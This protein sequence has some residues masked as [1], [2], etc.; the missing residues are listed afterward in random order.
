MLLG[1]SLVKPY[2]S[3]FENELTAAR[4]GVARIHRQVHHD[5]IELAGVGFHHRR[6]GPGHNEDFHILSQQRTQQFRD[7]S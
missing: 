2:G 7:L 4:H 3:S 1:K 5:L 6:P